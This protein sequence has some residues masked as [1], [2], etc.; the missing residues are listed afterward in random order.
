MSLTITD[1]VAMET[2][3]TELWVVSQTDM[4]GVARTVVS[5]SRSQAIAHFLRCVYLFMHAAPQDKFRVLGDDRDAVL[6]GLH[7]I[8]EREDVSLCVASLTRPG[9]IGSDPD[10]SPTNR[11]TGAFSVLAGEIQAAINLHAGKLDPAEVEQLSHSRAASILYGAITE[12]MIVWRY[13]GVTKHI[14]DRFKGGDIRFLLVFQSFCGSPI[15]ELQTY[16][17]NSNNCR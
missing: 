10:W 9:V 12:E 11:E 2:S 3:N 4:S 8:W 5:T 6:A 16:S 17:A 13:R 15:M 14:V 7:L 1:G